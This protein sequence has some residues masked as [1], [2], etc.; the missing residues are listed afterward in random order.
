MP[1]RAPLAALAAATTL[2]LAPSAAPARAQGAASDPAFAVAAVGFDS[3]FKYRLQPGDRRS[4]KLRVVSRSTKP[5]EVV[6][7]AADVTTAATGGLEY[8]SAEPRA[9]GTW[10]R[11]GGRT[12]TVPPGRAVEVP[13]TLRVPSDAQ[14]GDHLAGLVAI[15][16][17]QLRAARRNGDKEGFSLRFLPRLAIAVQ[18]TVPGDAST[19]LTVGN[20]GLDVRPTTT[21][22]TVLIR[23]SGDKLIPKT[24]GR[25]TVRRGDRV[26]LEREVDLDAFVPGTTVQYRLPLKG[27]PARGT[28][29][30]SG[31]LLPERG[32]PVPVNGSAS[33][34]EKEAQKF[35]DQTG[36]QAGDAGP[37]TWLII[38]IAVLVIV[39]LAMGAA[40]LA[41][42]R[43]LAE[44]RSGGAPP[45]S[46]A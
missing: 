36:Q 37:S 12:V 45:A 15:N 17:D 28:Y 16:R 25:L 21:D 46:R 13:F 19:E 6:L 41:M 5:Q 33:F 2:C 11:L 30:V 29:A 10:L 20:I 42:R 27:V 4:G 9:T 18:T 31:E 40:L 26:L 14:P 38:G 8:G 1:R 22:V 24:R 7:Q 32:A 3:F 39:L 44:A 34:A 43:R 23:N 35:E